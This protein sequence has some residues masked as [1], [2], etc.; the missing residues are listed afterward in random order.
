MMTIT[1]TSESAGTS[2]A[3]LLRLSCY[4]PFA[5][6]PGSALRTY[7]GRRYCL[8]SLYR[9]PSSEILHPRTPYVVS[10]LIGDRVGALM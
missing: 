5:F 1:D 7:F 6:L 8:L 4:V 10:I 9:I 2:L 3:P